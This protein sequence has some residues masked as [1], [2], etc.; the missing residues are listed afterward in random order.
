MRLQQEPN[1]PMT[2]PGPM[3]SGDPM[4]KS[5][6]VSKDLAV[7]CRPE[8][9]VCSDYEDCKASPNVPAHCCPA[10]IV[11]AM[12]S[13]DAT[14]PPCVLSETFKTSGQEFPVGVNDT[15]AECNSVERNENSRQAAAAAKGTVSGKAIGAA[16]A[17]DGLTDYVMKNAPNSEQSTEAQAHRA[18]A[19]MA[20]GVAAQQA[21]DPTKTAQDI[22]PNTDHAVSA[23]DAVRA[24]AE[25]IAAA[26][27]QTYDTQAPHAPSVSPA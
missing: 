22:Q 1:Q 23:R 16:N 5:G 6:I 2:H 27:T 8:C 10:L 7:C 18:D 15:S 21:L 11:K 24:I 25:G 4:C 14:H 13:C 19:Q 17:A 3:P 26:K 20:A 12:E 9:S